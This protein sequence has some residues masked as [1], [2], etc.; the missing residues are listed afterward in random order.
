MS[1]L[2]PALPLQPLSREPDWQAPVPVETASAD[3]PDHEAV[4]T[5]EFPHAAT[6]SPAGNIIQTARGV[7]SSTARPARLRAGVAPTSVS[8]R[9]GN[10]STSKT[11]Q[12]CPAPRR[13]LHH[14]AANSSKSTD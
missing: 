10:S 2:V 1:G 7:Y 6:R 13:P 8:C 3:P 5:F 9:A 4:S 12:E 14:V 11:T